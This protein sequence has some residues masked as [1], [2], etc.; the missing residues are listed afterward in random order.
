MHL[1]AWLFSAVIYFT[2]SVLFQ[3]YYQNL[4]LMELWLQLLMLQLYII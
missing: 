3:L 4:I 2:L 1:C